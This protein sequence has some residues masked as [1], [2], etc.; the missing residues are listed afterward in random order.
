MMPEYVVNERGEI[1][2]VILDIEEY[3]RAFGEA[4]A[5]RDSELEDF[6]ADF[7]ERFYEDLKNLAER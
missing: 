1:T 4:S 7:S 2:R 6:A 3:R 5:E